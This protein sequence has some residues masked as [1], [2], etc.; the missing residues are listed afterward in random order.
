MEVVL[1]KLSTVFWG[2]L[3]SC[4]EIKLEPAKHGNPNGTEDP[5]G[6]AK[7]NIIHWIIFPVFSR[8][9]FI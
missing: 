4:G 7:N 9:I 3:P 6:P 8:R 1:L 2:T 5:N